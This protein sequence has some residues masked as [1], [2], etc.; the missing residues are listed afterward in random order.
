MKFRFPNVCSIS[1]LV[2]E[3]IKLPV[4]ANSI[5]YLTPGSQWNTIKGKISNFIS[6]IFHGKHVLF[7]R[8]SGFFLWL[9]SRKLDFPQHKIFLLNFFSKIFLTWNF[10][11]FFTEFYFREFFEEKLFFQ[12]FR[13]PF[14]LKKFRGLRG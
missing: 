13:I 7:Q 10:G 2:D 9:E 12:R 3:F 1:L 14:S 4:T 5:P 8:V 11:I 6:L